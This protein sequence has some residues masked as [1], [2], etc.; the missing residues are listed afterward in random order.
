[1]AARRRGQ[2]KLEP[3][4]VAT[5]ML[6]Y[7]ARLPFADQITVD[8]GDLDLARASWLLREAADKVDQLDVCPG[9]TVMAKG[10]PIQEEQ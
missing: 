9:I 8:V 10:E 6:W 1:M 5:I 7:D 3:E 4:Q 2:P